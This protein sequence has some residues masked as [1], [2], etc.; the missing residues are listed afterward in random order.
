ME[1]RLKR[2]E[3][4]LIVISILTLTNLATLFLKNNST[5]IGK[6]VE[7]IELKELPDDLTKDIN[8]KTV[9]KIKIAFNLSDWNKMYNIFGEWTKVQIDTEQ[10]EREF[11]KLK[12]AI[13]NIDTYAYSRYIYEG[14]GK[15]ADWFEI[16]Y[17]CRFDK[18]NGTIKISTRTT[19][20][21]SEIC[22]I[23]IVL[24]EL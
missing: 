11:I 24:D 20:G 12:P 13:G 7:Q 15:G 16:Y 23:N 9:D 5:S 14:N 21:V 19:D 6:E 10:I 8:D 22:G 2:I 4:L 1:K 18:G 3:I 17:K